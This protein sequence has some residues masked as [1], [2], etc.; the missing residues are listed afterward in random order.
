[1]F[2]D[3]LKKIEK[4]KAKGKGEKLADLCSHKA[5]EVRLKAVDALGGLKGN[6][7]AYNELVMHVHD[8]DTEMRLHAIEA[9]GML[10]DVKARAHIEHQS[11]NEKDEK[12]RIAIQRALK[13]L[14]GSGE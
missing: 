12:V 13:M 10:R 6:E 4:Y 14:K 9:L 3:P 2:G 5:K 7:E 11:K 1:M 8:E